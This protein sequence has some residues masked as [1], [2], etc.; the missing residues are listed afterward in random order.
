MAKEKKVTLATGWLK[1][2]GKFEEVRR[3]E[4][5]TWAA[6]HLITELNDLTHYGSEVEEELQKK[7]N[8]MKFEDGVLMSSVWRKPDM[9][10]TMEQV[11]WIDDNQELID[12][13]SRKFIDE[14]VYPESHDGRG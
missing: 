4:Q 5:T 1:P 12:P 9:E 11:Y 7:Y 2:D 8:Y 13:Y 10:F 3:S 6:R 14:L